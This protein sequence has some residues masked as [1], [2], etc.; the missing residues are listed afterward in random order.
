MSVMAGQKTHPK[1]LAARARV[2]DRPSNACR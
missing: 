2:S 1:P